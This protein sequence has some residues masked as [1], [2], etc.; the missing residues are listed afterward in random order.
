MDQFNEV[1]AT[2]RGVLEGTYNEPQAD[3]RED[4][5]IRIA[6]H[7]AVKNYFPSGARIAE[8]LREARQDGDPSV[9]ENAVGNQNI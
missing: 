3:K 8:H 5:L 4:A 1:E 9:R 6:L 2:Y 7:P